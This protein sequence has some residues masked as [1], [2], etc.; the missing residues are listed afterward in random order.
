MGLD[1]VEILLEVEE[2][3]GVQI[4]D[5]VA[6]KC[7]TV[8]DLQAVVVDL[9]VQQG[10]TRSSELQDEVFKGLVEIS[11]EQMGIN[12]AKVRPESRWVGD[13]TWG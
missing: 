13:I 1:S 2:R 10:R 8:A 7:V 12:P 11:V 4:S 6:L 5:D 9:L 3:F